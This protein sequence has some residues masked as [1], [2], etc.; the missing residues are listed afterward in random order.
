MIQLEVPATT[1]NL[2][3]G[4]DCIGAA[5]GITNK[6]IVETKPDGI[7]VDV[8]G[9]GAGEI[10]RNEENLVIKAIK[11]VFDRAGTSL[12]GIKVTLINRIPIARGLG[13]SAACIVGGVVA[14]NEILNKP[15]DNQQL[16]KIAVEMEGHPD[17][18]V[19][20]MLGGIV[21]S[22]VDDNGEVR[23]IKI[24]NKIPFKLVVVV[25]DF[26]VKTDNARK[27][28]PETVNYR[29][30]VFNVGRASMLAASLALGEFQ[31]LGIAV[32]DRLHQPYRKQLIPC[33]DMIMETAKA[34]GA[35]AC[36]LSGAGPSMVAIMR[37]QP[38]ILG[39]AIKQIYK[40]KG[41]NCSLFYT[42][43]TSSGIRIK[44][45]EVHAYG[46]HCKKIRG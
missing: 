7:E 4:F 2:G 33:M 1:A 29:D 10:K 27:V 22:I 42:H 20:A 40:K 13:S 17:N 30:A 23:F 32:E 39:N 14:A 28:L 21:V 46:N 24:P 44:H 6:I 26:I 34:Y 9:E 31:H 19:P 43:I 11:K 41:I 18:V 12:N 38:Q 5:L 16:L 15:F 35:V 37:E 3:S 36:F 45:A 25:P 8:I